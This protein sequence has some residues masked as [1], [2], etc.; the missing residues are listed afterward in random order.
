MA[1]A[2]A[3]GVGELVT[4]FDEAGTSL[5]TTV[6]DEFIDRFAASLKDLAV[7]LFGTNDK[8]ALVVGIVVVALAIGA[9]VG[10]LARRRLRVGTV[11]FG[12]FGVLGALAYRAAPQASDTVGIIA[13]ALAALGGIAT[14]RFLLRLGASTARSTPALD[15]VAVTD[16]VA[17]GDEIVTAPA[18]TPMT[19]P[20]RRVFLTAAASLS[21]G[22]AGTAMLGRRLRG[23]DPAAAF[24]ADTVL[25]EPTRAAPPLAQPFTEDGLTPYIVPN[26]AFYR[27]DTALTIPRV[28]PATWRLDVTGLVDRPYSLSLDELLAMESVEVPVT[29]LCVSNLVGGDLAGNA[30]WQGVPL[31]ALLERAGVQDAGTQVLGRSVDGFTAGFPTELASDGRPALVAYGMNGDLLPAAHGFPAR[32][33]VSGLYGYVSATKWLAAIDL[34]PFDAVDGYWVPRGWAKEA[35][36][37]TSSRIDVPR[38]GTALPPGPT[39]VAGVAWAPTRGISAVEVQIDD[40]EW[41]ACELGDATN[42]HTWVQWRLVWDAQPGEHVLRVRATDGEGAVQTAEVTSP[43]P[44]GA[45]GLHARRIV[46]R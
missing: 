28:D 26:D 3:L 2:V 32:L 19:A 18:S 38:G 29:L 14:L 31:D 42:E 10:T 40:G 36:V 45:T 30:V 12:A 15:P 4:G 16:G 27:I 37:K 22:A 20:N 21:V 7:R 44:D 13:A 11:A 6:G 9:W 39:A 8:V 17:L 1:A 23:P 24:R 43:A 46:V 25:P 34:T 5:V 41:I 33:V 35:P